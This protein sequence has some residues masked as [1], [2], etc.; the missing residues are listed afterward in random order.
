MPKILIRHLSGART[1]QVDELPPN[2]TGEI[3]VGRDPDCAVA[4]DADR[5]DLVS[6]NH[7]KI[8]ADPANPGS[9]LV[10]DLQ[11]RNG[12][13]LNRQR[14][15]GSM[16]ITHNDVVQLGPGGPEFRFE[17][18]PP[19]VNQMHPPRE[20]GSPVRG[21]AGVQ[22]TREIL[23]PAEGGY[24]APRPIGRAT[25]ERILGDTFIKVKHESN[26]A[27]WV[28]TAALAA[29]LAVGGVSFFLLRQNSAETTAQAQQNQQLIQQMDVAV[30]K[31]PAATEAMKQEVIRLRMDMRSAQDRSEKILAALA[32]RL[33]SPQPATTPDATQDQHPEATAPAAAPGLAQTPRQADYEGALQRAVELLTLGRSE[34]HT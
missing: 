29:I 22:P 4:L 12:S 17:L 2:R 3:M 34:E 13:F 10:L 20:A 11:S 31:A 7:L 30:K 16:R 6:R 27:V 32:Q 23:S 14:I 33:S 18:D 25:V 24:A 1:N 5:D 19:P 28:G 26:K 9:Y 8:A 21:L 15:Y